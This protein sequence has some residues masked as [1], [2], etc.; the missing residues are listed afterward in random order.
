M[1]RKEG[2]GK[3][4]ID[5]FQEDNLQ[6]LANMAKNLHLDGGGK[7]DFY[8]KKADKIVNSDDQPYALYEH[9]YNRMLSLRQSFLKRYV[10]LK[11]RLKNNGINVKFINYE[12]EYKK[13]LNKTL[14]H[15]KKLSPNN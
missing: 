1:P 13:A 15:N 14:K 2:E 12:K 10:L 8:I 4:L 6:L 9:D 11:M 3:K 5:I 7:I